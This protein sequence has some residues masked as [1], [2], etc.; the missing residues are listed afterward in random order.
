MKYSYLL[1]VLCLWGSS[2]TLQAHNLKAAFFKI[3]QEGKVYYMDI[4]L[5]EYDV[6]ETL[7]KEYPHLK[8]EKN[9]QEFKDCLVE[10]IEN[11]L[12]LQFDLQDVEVDYQKFQFKK[13]IIKVFTQLETSAQKVQK[14]KVYNTCLVEDI[15]QQSNLLKVNLYNRERTFRL[16]RG[17][18]KTVVDYAK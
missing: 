8:K 2:S 14:I 16:H 7:K 18:K 4:T 5:D 15:P 3:Y 12:E 10:Y 1:A 9:K 11:N 13:D 17:R 6:T